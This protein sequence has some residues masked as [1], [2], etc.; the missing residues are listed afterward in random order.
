MNAVFFRDGRVPMQA[1]LRMNINGITGLKDGALGSPAI[2][3]NNDA[4]TGPYL[5]GLNQYGIQVNSVQRGVFTTA[6]LDVTGALTATTFTEGGTLLSAKYAAKTNPA[7]TGQ[8]TADKFITNGV[9]GAGIIINPQNAGVSTSQ[10]YSPANNDLR[11]YQGLDSLQIT[12]T[13]AIFAGNVE[14]KGM[15]SKGASSGFYA[16]PRDGTTTQVPVVYSPTTGDLRLYDGSGDAAIFQTTGITFNRS[17]ASP[18]FTGTPVAPTPSTADSSTKLATTAYVQNN[19]ANYAALNAINVFVGP[20]GTSVPI[21]ALTANTTAG[22]RIMANATSG[23]AVLDFVNN[24]Y[25]LVYGSIS[26]DAAGMAITPVGSSGLSLGG[27]PTCAT[28]SAGDT[29]T[30]VATTAFVDR[31]RSLTSFTTTGRTLGTGDRGNVVQATGGVTVPN[32]TFSAGDVVIVYNNT[33]GNLTITQGTS[34]TLRQSGTANTGN[35]TLA[36]RGQASILFLSSSEAVV[37][38]DIT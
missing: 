18:T 17:I 12:P 5:P 33:A 25:T 20:G 14:A 28:Q 23:A 9:A 35:R 7:I 29:S 8:I 32:A 38:G 13:L 16:F 3:F 19:L 15:Y 31:L 37:S 24:A 27:V 11:V 22:V 26:V 10:F 1:D 4:G 30:K 36:Q 2:K 21:N 6:G 34:L